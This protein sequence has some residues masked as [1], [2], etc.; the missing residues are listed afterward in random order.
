VDARGRKQFVSN[1]TAYVPACDPDHNVGA[2]AQKIYGLKPDFQHPTM[3]SFVLYEEVVRNKTSG[4]NVMQVF[5]A[6]SLPVHNFLAREGA[7][8]ELMW[9]SV[10]GPTW[11]NR[12]FSLMAT[13]AG[14]TDTGDWSGMVDGALFPGR[15]IFDQCEDAGWTLS[16]LVLG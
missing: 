7:M 3:G 4:C 14:L 10:P 6:T 2:T 16:L 11:P 8:F 13:S 5:N 1:A 9:P 12:W 15:T